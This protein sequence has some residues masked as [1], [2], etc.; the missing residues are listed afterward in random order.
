MVHGP[1]DVIPP[2]PKASALAADNER[3]RSELERAVRIRTQVLSAMSHDLRTPLTTIC[4]ATELL[5]R[6]AGQDAP[7]AVAQVMQGLE[8]VDR[9][10]KQLDS[11]I[12]EIRDFASLEDGQALALHC[13]WVDLVPLIQRI[14][15]DLQADTDGQYLRVEVGPNELLG[16][17]DAR[18]L[19]RIMSKLISNALHCSPEAATVTVQVT[20]DRPRDG[21]TGWA[22]TVVRFESAGI[23][24]EHLTHLLDGGPHGLAR[25]AG[26]DL[27][28][29]REIAEQHGGS[30]TVH[31]QAGAGSAFTLLLPLNQA[32][33]VA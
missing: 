10:A 26:L 7:V 28:G 6:L 29:C 8:L 20:R 31:S 4:G 33:P 30:L 3:L 19:E 17:W 9:A 5:L 1:E 22:K 21:D 15:A 32:E 16:R 14:T 27:A 18:R 23:A 25:G 13:E 24:S 2:K 12:D 11:L